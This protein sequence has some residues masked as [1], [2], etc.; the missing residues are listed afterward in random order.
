M[1]TTTPPDIAGERGARF[2]IRCW[3]ARGTIPSPGARTVRYGG[4]TSCVEVRTR[5]DELLVFDAG[6]G[7][8]ALGQQLLLHENGS[9]T[10]RP[11]HLFLTHHH[12]DHVMGL[13]HFAPLFRDDRRLLVTS[14]AADPEVTRALVHALLSPPL[15]PAPPALTERVSVRGFDNGAPSAIGARSVVHR[16][17]ANHPGGASIF[18]VDDEKG[19]GIAFAPDN[20]LAYDSTDAEVIAWRRGLTLALHGV[21][22]LLH[23]ATYSDAELATHRGW[24]HSSALEAT[25]FAMECVAG[26]LVLFHHHPDRTD[27]AV[28]AV[29]QECRQLV[30]IS[31]SSL[32]V[33]AAW[34]GLTLTV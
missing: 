15:F 11:T 22:V 16:F 17:P 7:L 27:D 10:S 1:S 21:P 14:G 2:R 8:R 23:D 24:G 32:R 18:R 30:S 13:P 25:R 5:A 20:E 28:D 4:N 3:G 33:I 9:D 19:S 29:V 31:G 12:S 26:M 6:T 34:E